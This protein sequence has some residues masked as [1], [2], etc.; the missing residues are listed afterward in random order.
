MQA[1]QIRPCE[2]WSLGHKVQCYRWIHPAEKRAV[3]VSTVRPSFLI[4]VL[5]R[6][7]VALYY[8]SQ[9][10]VTWPGRRADRYCKWTPLIFSLGNTQ[11]SVLSTAY[12]V[13]CFGYVAEMKEGEPPPLTIA[14]DADTLG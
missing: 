2:T 5:I 14:A 10:G 11:Y 1:D 8:S 7:I 9:V 6:T 4:D 3:S 12:A 13:C